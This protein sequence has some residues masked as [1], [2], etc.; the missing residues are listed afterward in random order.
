[1]IKWYRAVERG[2]GEKGEV[3]FMKRHQVEGVKI[4]RISRAWLERGEGGISGG[5]N[6]AQTIFLPRRKCLGQKIKK[7]NVESHSTLLMGG[8]T[9]STR[10]L[11]HLSVVAC[12]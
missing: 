6:F 8:A 2:R 9:F 5:E 1:M 3:E 12:G 7:C 10:F 11:L 4:W